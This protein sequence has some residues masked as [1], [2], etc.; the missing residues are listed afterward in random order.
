MSPIEFLPMACGQMIFYT[1]WRLQANVFWACFLYDF[2]FLFWTHLLWIRFAQCACS[3]VKGFR[4]VLCFSVLFRLSFSHSTTYICILMW[5]SS[6][7]FTPLSIYCLTGETTRVPWF[8]NRDII[9]LWF[10]FHLVSMFSTQ[11]VMTYHVSCEV[12]LLMV[13]CHE[14]RRRSHHLFAST[15]NST[16]GLTSTAFSFICLWIDVW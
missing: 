3:L 5:K 13:V 14:Q 15:H 2:L 6:W 16:E 9:I 12:E 7:S 10:G 8:I 4:I 1:K 11:T